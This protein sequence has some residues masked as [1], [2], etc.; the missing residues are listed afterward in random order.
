[1]L[2]VNWCV[3]LCCFVNFASCEIKW[4]KY[5]AP[6]LAPE[7]RA[8]FKFT[9]EAYVR[10]PMCYESLDL[11][12]EATRH[13]TFEIYIRR[14]CPTTSPARHIWYIAGGPGIS[15]D[16]VEK[17]IRTKFDD[18]AIYIMDPRGLDRSQE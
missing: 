6:Y 13:K 7:M 1:M 8:Y 16:N 10:V 18:L 11:Q 15:S 17:S 2:C 14:F 3:A 9:S 5:D 12:S 4:Q